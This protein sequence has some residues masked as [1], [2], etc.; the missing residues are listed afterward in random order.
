M[1]VF[2]DGR[3]PLSRPV[4]FNKIGPVH[5]DEDGDTSWTAD[6]VVDEPREPQMFETGVLDPRGQPIIRVCIPVKLGR[7]GFDF[8]HLPEYA[9]ALAEIDQCDEV[10]TYTTHDQLQVVEDAPGQGLAYVTPEELEG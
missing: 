1:R 4:R 3:R 7:I 5:I 8:S 10:T 6:T 2:R 9:A